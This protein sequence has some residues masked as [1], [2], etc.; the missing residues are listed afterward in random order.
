MKC[1]FCAAMELIHDTRDMP[2]TYQGESTII[3]EVTGD[4]CSACDESILNLSESRRTMKLMLAFNQQVNS[5]TLVK[6]LKVLDRHPELINEI[7]M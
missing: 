4:F 5:S 1:P 7:R 3:P 2:Y 6:L